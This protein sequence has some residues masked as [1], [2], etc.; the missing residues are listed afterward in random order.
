[1][2]KGTK[3]FKCGFHYIS[4]QDDKN[5]EYYWWFLNLKSQI[6]I[7]QQR[8]DK[9]DIS[10]KINFE[11]NL[12]KISHM[13]GKQCQIWDADYPWQNKF[14]DEPK[15]MYDNQLTEDLCRNAYIEGDVD[16]EDGVWC[17]TLDEEQRWDYC[18]VRRCSD[19]DTG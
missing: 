19:C 13:L 18:P 3:F 5:E 8:F 12:I 6:K 14:N 2:E 15:H 17:Y 9:M 11:N 10:L 7:L 4:D 1:M 16:P